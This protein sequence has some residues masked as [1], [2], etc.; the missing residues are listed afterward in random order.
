MSFNGPSALHP[1][2]R[3][4]QICKQGKR[5]EN[6]MKNKRATK[7]QKPPRLDKWRQIAVAAVAV[8]L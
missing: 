4:N 3:E 2:K 1:K 8:D 7:M 6:N 5:K